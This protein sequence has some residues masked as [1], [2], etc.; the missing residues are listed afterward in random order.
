MDGLWQKKADAPARLKVARLSQMRALARRFDGEDD[1]SV[2][3][4]VLRLMPN[5]MVRYEDKKNGVIDGALFA[6]V[7]GTDPELLIMLEARQPKDKSGKAEYF[8]ALAPMT[9]A[10]LE[11]YLDGDHVWTKPQANGGQTSIFYMRRLKGG[12]P[13]PF[14]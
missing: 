3:A 14:E 5:P 2:E 6:M 12:V 1:L 13:F 8:W 10:K 9:S 4:N 7:E 11:G